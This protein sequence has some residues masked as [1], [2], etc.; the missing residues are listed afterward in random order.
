[1][2]IEQASGVAGQEI[3]GEVDPLQIATFDLEVATLGGTGTNDCS[4]KFLEQLVRRVI[5]TDVGVAEEL[6]ALSFHLAEAPED[7]LFLVQLHVGNAIHQQAAGTIGTF[8]DGYPMARAIELRCSTQSGGARADYGYL[9]VGAN[10][11]RFRNYPT[12][13]PT[14]FNYRVFEVFDRDRRSIDA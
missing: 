1:M 3:H 9:L 7:Y 10:F 13:L 5:S 12:L 8:E 6:D 2:A 11:G 4:V 14:F